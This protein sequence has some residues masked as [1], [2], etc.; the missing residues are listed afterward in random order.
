[1]PDLLA[2]ALIAYSLG[3]L[4]SWCYE[5]ISPAYVTVAMAGA[6]I[7]DL[8][9]VMLVLPSDVV[10]AWLSMPFDWYALHTL[11]GSLVSVALGVA[12]VASVERKRIAALLGL[13]ATSHL[14][15]DL[16]LLSPS[17]HSFP[18][19][20]PLSYIHPPTIDLYLSTQPE[21]MILAAVVAGVLFI[22]TRLRTRSD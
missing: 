10:A 11:G 13:G 2:H 22:M 5:W 9:K 19:L 6:F 17:G 20:W 1:M 18:V 12:L 21:P 14:F 8:T 7:P 15:A 4:L 3:T 16:L